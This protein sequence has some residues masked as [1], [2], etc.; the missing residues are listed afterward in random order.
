MDFDSMDDLSFDQREVLARVFKPLIRERT[1]GGKGEVVRETETGNV[2]EA[3]LL[4][5]PK[6]SASRP[7]KQ[8]IP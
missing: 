6:T 2:K 7:D 1:C 3:I 5:H 8:A 4:C